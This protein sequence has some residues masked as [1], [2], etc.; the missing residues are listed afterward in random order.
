MGGA[1]LRYGTAHGLGAQYL[2]TRLCTACT[3][4]WTYRTCT[5][6]YREDI[7]PTRLSFIGRCS[8]GD[9]VYAATVWR[10][11]EG[12]HEVAQVRHCVWEDPCC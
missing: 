4:L 5:R 2:G 12:V 6:S 9:F 10:C 7:W 11:L 8:V 1:V 3:E